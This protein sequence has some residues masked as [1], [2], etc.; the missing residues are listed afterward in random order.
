[1]A[2]KI[3]IIA[4]LLCFA[5]CFLPA[6]S[7]AQIDPGCNPDEACPIDN[8]LLLLLAIPIVLAVKKTLHFRKRNL[9]TK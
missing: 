7:H 3:S 9:I 8:G 6:Y 1:M 4:I 2:K 5:I